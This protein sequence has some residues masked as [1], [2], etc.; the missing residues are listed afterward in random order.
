M[1]ESQTQ[2]A[3]YTPNKTALVTYAVA[4]GNGQSGSSVAYLS[5]AAGG[6]PPAKIGSGNQIPATALGKGGALAG[7]KLTVG[8]LVVDTNTQTDL[9][10]ATVTV[11]GGDA[12]LVVT[13]KQQTTAGGSFYFLSIITFT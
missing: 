10:I 7:K 12:P 6:P 5:D 2:T 9:V 4:I 11:T 13:Q 8:T 3:V 1:P